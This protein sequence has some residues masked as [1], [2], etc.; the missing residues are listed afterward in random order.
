MLNDVRTLKPTKRW[1]PQLFIDRRQTQCSA[2]QWQGRAPSWGLNVW[3]EEGVSRARVWWPWRLGQNALRSLWCD[4]SQICSSLV[5]HDMVLSQFKV[6][7]I[8]LEN[9][10]VLCTLYDVGGLTEGGVTEIRD[11]IEIQ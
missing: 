6:N 11:Q 4:L 2:L 10:H 5:T 7:V 3:Q 9:N 8:W 1:Y